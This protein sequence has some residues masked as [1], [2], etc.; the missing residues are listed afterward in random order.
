MFK[1]TLFSAFFALLLLMNVG[2]ILAQNSSEWESD[3]ATTE[4]KSKDHSSAALKKRHHIVTW[5]IPALALGKLSGGYEFMFQ[6]NKSIKL[7][8][9]IMLPFFNLDNL[10][11]SESTYRFVGEFVVSGIDI[12]P[13]IRFYMGKNAAYG[14]GFYIAPYMRL[15]SYGTDGDFLRINEISNVITDKGILDISLRQFGFGLMLGTQ[16]V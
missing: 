15:A 6:R 2:D 9:G 14:R 1:R 12:S 4:E 10:E 11:S 3:G 8:G 16:M 13:E 5:N 7:A